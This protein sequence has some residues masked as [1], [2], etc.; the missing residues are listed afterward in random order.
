[1]VI[2]LIK[3]VDGST[4]WTER[5]NSRAD[6]D[7]WLSEEKTRPYWK[8]DFTVEIDDKEKETLEE[9]KRNL[10]KIQARTKKA[11]EARLE[12]KELRKKKGRTAAE[13]A[14]LL[15]KLLDAL[16]IDDEI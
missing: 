7:A 2:I 10:E 13:N 9:Q 14:A 12:V 15:D 4:Y 6:C 16:G 5:F 3:N 1:M 8:K 11:Q